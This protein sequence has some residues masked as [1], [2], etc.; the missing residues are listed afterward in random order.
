MML[1]DIVRKLFQGYCLHPAVEL[2]A[3]TG[4]MECVSSPGNVVVA[5]SIVCRRC[6]WRMVRDVRAADS[7]RVRMVDQ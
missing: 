5:V 7:L 2:H 6:G 1:F 3:C 4:V